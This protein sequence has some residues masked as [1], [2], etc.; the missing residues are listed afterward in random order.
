MPQDKRDLP[1]PNNAS[2]HTAPAFT[3][4]PQGMINPGPGKFIAEKG[5]VVAWEI[6]N[7][8]N[9][10]ITVTLMD[11]FRKPNIFHRRGDPH[12]PVNDY[13]GWIPN[14]NSYSLQL[15]GPNPNQGFLYAMILKKPK[16]W[17]GDSLSYTIRVT[18]ADNSFDIYWDPDGDI[19]P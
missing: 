1:S 3:V 19:K 16:G 8:S 11:F 13:F 5:E 6:T 15:G 2:P 12:D 7:A 10:Q 17:L 18:A 14:P 4:G 9:Q